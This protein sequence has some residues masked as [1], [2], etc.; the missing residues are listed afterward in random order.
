L[1]ANDELYCADLDWFLTQ[2]DTEH[3]WRTNFGGFVAMLERGGSSSGANSSDPYHELYVNRLETFER[4]RRLSLEWTQLS[5]PIKRVL[6]AHYAAAA[7]SG[8]CKGV[9]GELGKLAGTA[10]LIAFDAGELGP[11]LDACSNPSADG[12][13][14]RIAKVRN[15]AEAA[16]RDAHRAY[17]A[18][19][20]AALDAWV[21]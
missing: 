13:G 17:Y 8:W 21:A 19:T 6:R 5:L 10:V 2:R 15:L 14:D 11:F 12:A 16:A 7:V 3:G 9:A 1:K 20:G 18:V 4:D